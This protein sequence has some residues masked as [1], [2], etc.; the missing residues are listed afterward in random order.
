MRIEG[1][2]AD[3]ADKSYKATL[4]DDPE[5]LKEKVE[6]HFGCKWRMTDNDNGIERF[7]KMEDILRGSIVHLESSRRYHI[8]SQYNK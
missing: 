7:E 3:V 6:D 1:P 4:C 2:T 5:E 8:L